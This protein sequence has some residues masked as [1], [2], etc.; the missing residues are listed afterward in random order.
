M[1]CNIRM[2]ADDT[3]MYSHITKPEDEEKLQD[4][5]LDVCDWAAKWQMSFNPKKRKTMRLGRGEASEYFMKDNQGKIHKIEAVQEGKDLG[6][7]FHKDVKF[8]KHIKIKVESTV[9]HDPE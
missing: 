4:D 6:V 1:R 5:I 3:K 7:T 8:D 9:H 2:F